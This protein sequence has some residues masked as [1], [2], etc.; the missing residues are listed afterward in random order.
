[1]EA[2]KMELTGQIARTHDIYY[3]AHVQN[4]GWLD[5]ARNGEVAGSYGLALRVEAFQVK[6]VAKGTDPG[7]ST[8][9][10]FVATPALL[11]STTGRGQEAG[12]WTQGVSGTTGKSLPLTSFSAKTAEKY[13]MAGGVAYRVNGSG[14]AWSAWA[15]DG[16]AAGGSSVHAVEMKL[17]GDLA[18][19]F[20]VWYRVHLSGSGWLGWAK[21]G[22]SAGTLD[23]GRTVEAV[24]ARI[25]SKSASAPG[26]NWSFLY[27]GSSAALSA[28]VMQSAAR[29]ASPPEGW[30]AR[31]ITNV[32]SGAGLGYVGGN[33]NDM[34]RRYAT[35]ADR[36]KLV[37]G[38]VVAV[39][40]HELTRAGR[41]WGHIGIYAGGGQIMDSVG[42]VRTMPLDAWIATYGTVAQVRWG[43]A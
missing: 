42:Y 29:T 7:L 1:M 15:S 21:N 23:T 19:R 37:P 2:L 14:H 10:P 43:F 38:M 11:V 34:Y 27:V 18:S 5:W 22:Q 33:A 17:T 24:E 41:V 32:Y 40:T 28:R 9:R 16:A 39:P 30:C 13:G 6:V 31:W 3:R 12:A 20:D 4:F 8:A 36:A 26:P 35:S 25:V